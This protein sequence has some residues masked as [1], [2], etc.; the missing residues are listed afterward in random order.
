MSQNPGRSLIAPGEGLPPQP[1][2]S[3]DYGNPRDYWQAI[4][5][6]V[7]D[8]GLI[9]VDQLMET[10]KELVDPGYPWHPYTSKHHIYNE[11]A[12][13]D[14]LPELGIYNPYRFRNLAINKVKVPR[15]FENLLHWT[16]RPAE[17]PD[18]DVR[19]YR[20][21]A[22]EVALRLW[23][24]AEQTIED[25]ALWTGR[26]ADIASRPDTINPEWQGEDRISDEH[27]ATTLEKHFY[28]IE[29]QWEL[30]EKI[31]PDLRVLEFDPSPE[32]VAQRLGSIVRGKAVN[33]VPLIAA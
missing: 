9:L 27:F 5:T 17:I 6:P 7:D 13:Y 28:I 20:V 21:E 24:K 22:W 32:V 19:A 14:N 12:W 30:N 31:P 1:F 4:P 23:R 26:M 18:A 15:Q 10:V 29:Q 11:A 3:I 25:E 33:F 2:V 8:R 16:T